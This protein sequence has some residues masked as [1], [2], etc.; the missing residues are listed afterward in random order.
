MLKFEKKIRRQKVNV[1]EHT[2]HIVEYC[3]CSERP[4]YHFSCAFFTIS[5]SCSLSSSDPNHLDISPPSTVGRCFC[6]ESE[7]Q[8]VFR[9]PCSARSFELPGTQI[10][11]TLFPT[12]RPR[13]SLRHFILTPVAIAR[14][15]QKK[16]PRRIRL[17]NNHPPTLFTSPS[18]LCLCSLLASNYFQPSLSY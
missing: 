14:F 13:T 15:T 17:S 5:T 18:N 4:V 11:S 1:T 2:L 9:Q 6:S 10:H 7:T 16:P 8:T 3:A 12:T